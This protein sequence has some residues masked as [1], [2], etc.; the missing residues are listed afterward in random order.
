[1][2]LLDGS[3]IL[4]VMD[5]FYY[6]RDLARAHWLL[7]TQSTLLNLYQD[8]ING[9]LGADQGRLFDGRQPDSFLRHRATARL[10]P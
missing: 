3:F 2:L 6:R 7:R 4:F 8:V 10:L 5:G 1:M 9:A